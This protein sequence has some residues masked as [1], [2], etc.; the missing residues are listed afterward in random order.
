MEK[1]IDYVKR[2]MHEMRQ[3]GTEPSKLQMS[4]SL[5]QMMMEEIFNTDET[6]NLNDVVCYEKDG[7]IHY[8]VCGLDFEERN[9]IAKET[10]FIVS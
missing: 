1:I 6:P 2:S 3:K 9:D 5:F 8:R 4:V 7:K 10:I